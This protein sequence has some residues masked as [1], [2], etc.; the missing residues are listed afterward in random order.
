MHNSK[1]SDLL[2]YH[3]LLTLIKVFAF[4][5]RH[6]LGRM[7]VV[8]GRLWYRLDGYHR[9]IAT[10]NMQKAFKNE[11]S[12]GQIDAMVK[13]NF[14]QLTRVGLEI[15]SLLK[16]NEH[17]VDRYVS[18]SGLGHLKQALAKENGILILTAHLGHWEM[19]ALTCN[20]KL[21]MPLNIL[22]RPLDYAPTDRILK[23]IRSRTGNRVLDKDNSAG[24]IGKL[25]RQKQMVGILLD[26]NSSWYEGVYVPF[27]GRIACTNKGLAVLARRY[28]AT[29][30]PVFNVRAKDGRYHIYID[31]PVSLISTG[32]IRNDIE[33]N[34]RRFNQIIEK[35]VRLAPD[36]WM[37]IHRRWRIKDIPD[38]IKQ[39]RQLHDAID[40]LDPRG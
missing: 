10:D 30:L 4:W 39:S 28:K 12:H 21:K 31:P 37:W 13:A 40:N 22:V 20:L 23:A 24:V 6:R 26:Q 5:P 18:I 29:V 38:E 32:D 1:K 14:I 9:H 2:I 35:Y 34:T 3:L 25:L 16:M 19:M 7:A 8:L 27:F 33:A 11:F 36:N 15:P 17:N